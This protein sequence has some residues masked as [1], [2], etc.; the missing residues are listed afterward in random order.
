MPSLPKLPDFSNNCYVNIEGVTQP[1]V[2]HQN[3]EY[4]NLFL[5]ALADI[6]PQHTQD[7]IDE[8]FLCPI[9][10]TLME[11][12]VITPE[13]TTYERE[14]L[15]TWL[16]HQTNSGEE[17]TDPICRRPLTKCQLRPNKIAARLTKE[18]QKI[19]DGEP[20]PVGVSDR[21]F[22]DVFKR[23]KEKMQETTERYKM[24]L[25]A[26]FATV[27]LGCAL[28]EGRPAAAS[29]LF[30]SGAATTFGGPCVPVTPLLA[31]GSAVGESV[32]NLGSAS[33]DATS[34][35]TQKI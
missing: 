24:L 33:A 23:F 4:R 3:V 22:A 31:T 2:S 30:A 18:Y 28:P 34:V 32:V 11:D 27:A 7:E 25:L 14:T 8:R 13:G 15:I 5:M 21:T 17:T 12:P 10:R 35:S 1:I 29:S 26:P 9:T 6:T 20:L 16:D 19:R